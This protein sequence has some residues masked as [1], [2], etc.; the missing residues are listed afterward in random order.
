MM[1][2]DILERAYACE[3]MLSFADRL[4]SDTSQHAP[5]FED[6]WNAISD[7]E[8]LTWLLRFAPDQFEDSR[9]D[10]IEVVHALCTARRDDLARR[11]ARSSV[12]NSV[13]G[14]DLWI[15]ADSCRL[16]RLYVRLRR[17]S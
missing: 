5:T 17:H 15:A 3:P 7:P 9:R 6:L 1:L 14:D 12:L 16:I 11:D 10:L 8:W 4:E 13:G 2:R